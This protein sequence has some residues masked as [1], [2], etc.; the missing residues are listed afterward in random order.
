MAERS[1]VRSRA[2]EIEAVL[3]DAETTLQDQSAQ[4][5]AAVLARHSPQYVEAEPMAA[6]AQQSPAGREWEVAEFETKLQVR[7]GFSQRV[8]PP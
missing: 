4:L 1:F 7:S 2:A 8:G 6:R 3:V 5:N